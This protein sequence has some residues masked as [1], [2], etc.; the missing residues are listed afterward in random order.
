MGD[1]AGA[2]KDDDVARRGQLA[3]H[4]RELFR[5]RQGEG[6]PV[7]VRGDCGRE[8][9]L[10]D[11]FD[12]R[13]ASRIDVGDDHAV[14]VVEAGREGV[15]QR[16]QPRIAMGLHDGDHLAGRG[17]P[18]GLEDG[19]DLDRMVAV[20]VVDRDPVPFARAGETPLDPAEGADRLADDVDRGAELV[21]DGDRRCG[22]QRIVPARHRQREIVDVGGPAGRPLADQH[23]EFGDA[24]VHGDVQEADIGLRV[25]AVGQNAPVLDPADQLV[26]GRMVVTHDGEAVERQV[27]DQRQ[28]GLLDRIESP[29]MVE[30]L[31]IDIGDDGD[32]GRQLQKGAVALVGLDHHPVA[33]AEPRVG[34][35]GVD[36]APVDDGRVEPGGVE[37]RRH[38]RGR[39]GLAMRAGDRDALLEAHELG[40]HLGAADDRNSSRAGCGQLRIVAPD[41][42]RDDDDRRRAQIGRIVADEHF[43]AVLAQALDVGVVARVRALH[44]VPEVDEDLGDARHADAADADEVDGADFLRQFHV[45]IVSREGRPTGPDSCAGGNRAVWAIWEMRRRDAG[46]NPCA[47]AKA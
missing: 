24:A 46:K 8:R 11:P 17:R 36:D 2:E 20:V 26:H 1:R 3:D 27:L 30:M 18:G 13:L 33:G 31:R 6:V 7:A 4:R 19:G 34:S 14:G 12:R 43:C 37:Q 25:L 23:G 28:K 45:A 21:R 22:V 44:G 35:V 40:Q 15:E 10:V 16:R 29:E 32:V 38:E 41:R 42:A 47:A 9:V 39:R 5:R